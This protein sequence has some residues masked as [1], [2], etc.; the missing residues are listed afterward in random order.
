MDTPGPHEIPTPPPDPCQP[1]IE[2]DELAAA[3]ARAAR[4][5]LAQRAPADPPPEK[6]SNPHRPEKSIRKNLKT[7][8]GR[9]TKLRPEVLQSPGLSLLARVL[10]SEIIGFASLNSG[11]CYASNVTLAKRILCTDRAVRENIRILERAGKIRV[12][13]RWNAVTNASYTNIIEP[14]PDRTPPNPEDK[15]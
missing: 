12:A 15:T 7:A 10:L 4:V 5:V 1:K 8:V 14:V 9:W 6:P 13:R 3:I 11:Q 2:D